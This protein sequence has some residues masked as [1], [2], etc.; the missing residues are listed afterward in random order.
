MAEAFQNRFRCEA[1]ILKI[2]QRDDCDENH[3]HAVKEEFDTI[4]QI[5]EVEI[6]GHDQLHLSYPHNDRYLRTSK[7][8][9]EW[10]LG[11]QLFAKNLF[12]SPGNLWIE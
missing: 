7:A 3:V 12:E 10:L 6:I 2:T 4:C 11:V 9:G 8:P 5:T 1:Y